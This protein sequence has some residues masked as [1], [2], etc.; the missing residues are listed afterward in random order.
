MSYMYSTCY[1]CTSMYNMYPIMY[2]MYKLQVFKL[3]ITCV[4][5]VLMYMYIHVDVLEGFVKAYKSQTLL[6]YQVF[7]PSYRMLFLQ[8]IIFK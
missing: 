8:A 1:I 2:I 3:S 4:A 5:H 6:I 7:K